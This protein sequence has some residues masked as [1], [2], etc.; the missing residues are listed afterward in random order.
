M[1]DFIF[2]GLNLTFVGYLHNVR[3]RLYGSIVFYLE[4]LEGNKY[5]RKMKRSVLA[6]SFIIV[7]VAASVAQ[8]GPVLKFEEETFDFGTIQEKNGSVE[9]KFVFS[10]TG[11]APLIVQG[12]RASCGCTT[13]AWSREPVLPGSTGFITARYNPLNR[14]GPFR[15]SLTVTSN[16]TKPTVVIFIKGVVEGKPK[17]VADRYGQ[18][19]GNLRM[20]TRS[21]N[22]GKVTTEKTVVRSFDV[23]N[24]SDKSIRFLEKAEVPAHMKVNYQPEVL[25]PASVGKIVVSYDPKARNDLGFV[26]DRLVIYTDE[27]QSEQKDLR[28]V[29]TIE[30]YF[31]PMTKEQ[32][33]AAPKLTIE[34][35]THDFGTIQQDDKVSA[36]FIFTNTGKSELNIRNV[37]TNCGCTVSQLTKE[38]LQPGESS[39]IQVTFDSRGRRGMQQKLITV[40]SNDPQSPTQ[41][42]VIKA[43]VSES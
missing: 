9:H 12:V 16:A 23:Y 25:P 27:E 43:K 11:N 42:L 22:I 14:P 5:Q 2:E 28:V 32:L 40:F 4:R 36:E 41:R 33:E 1:P 31:P 35:T 17:T 10:N 37:K 29:A 15:K 24:D 7:I 34:K 38:T 21:L 30:E 18:Q 26:Y 39:T 13:P 3:E 19:M 6:L 20:K 8:D